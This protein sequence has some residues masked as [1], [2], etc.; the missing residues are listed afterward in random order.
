MAQLQTFSG[1][2][3]HATP[4]VRR[5]GFMDLRYALSQGLSDFWEQPSH[6]VFLC[7]FY[8]IIGLCIAFWASNE[9]VFPLLYP[10]MSGFALVGPVAAVGLYEISRR[11]EAGV[12]SSW[13]HV[14][15]I[16]RSPAIR[17]IAALSIVLAVVFIAWMATAQLIYNTIFIRSV[18]DSYLGFLNE[19]IST[20]RG[21]TLIAVGN[22][23]GFV[24]ALFAFSISVVS[25][26]LLLDQHVSALTAMEVSFQAVVK[27]PL[28]MATWALIIAAG[29][30]VGFLTLFVGL[31]IVLPVLG[32]ATWHLYRRVVE[33]M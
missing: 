14:F 7:L 2:G 30:V 17:S 19:I 11:R 18:A 16:L 31:A 4:R 22:L 29:L 33:P 21:W 26:P 15:A 27:N 28:V 23:V 5:I 9:N 12:D 10:L 6:I 3:I 24:Y 25:F 13:H 20:R 8:P 1:H 32:H